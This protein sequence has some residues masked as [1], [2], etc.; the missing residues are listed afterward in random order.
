MSTRLLLVV[1]ALAAPRIARAEVPA[2]CG[3]NHGSY[4]DRQ[5]ALDPD[6]ERAVAGIIDGLC[7]KS[8]YGNDAPGEPELEQ[9]RRV[10]SQRL[11]MTDADWADAAVWEHHA[12]L[13]R[14][15]STKVL[16]KMTAVD[17]LTL[18]LDPFPPA[19]APYLADVLEGHL[20]EAG[21]LALLIAC[22]GEGAKPIT[23]GQAGA[24]A[25][26]RG[27]LD[28]FDFKKLSDQLH[29]DTTS[30]GA[31]RFWARLHGYEMAQRIALVR[32]ATQKLVA[33]DAEYQKV[34]DTASAARSEWAKTLGTNTELLELAL[35]IDSGVLMKSQRQLEGCEAKTDAALAA[36]VATI[37]ARAFVGMHDQRDEP[38][39][40]FVHAVGPLLA[41]TPAT[42]LAL[43]AYV[44]CQPKRDNVQGAGHYL[45]DVPGF[46]GPRGA[47][48]SALLETAFKFDDPR[49]SVGFRYGERP[50]LGM[51]D[52]TRSAGGVVKS[53]RKT[54]KG[55]VVALVKTQIVQD[56]C[57]ASHDTGRITGIRDG[58]VEYQRVCD[59]TASVTH[60]TTW[61]DFELDAR[62]ASVLKPGVMFSAAGTDVIAV[63]PSKTAKTPSWVLGG[64]V[65]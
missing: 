16:A 53:V 36:A 4:S 41:S 8:R 15:L 30:S 43:I 20:T 51:I 25:V 31:S 19:S 18:M 27:D 65:K 45:N 42:N 35:G 50:Y 60:D 52:R 38:E 39:R 5:A 13:G 46:R 61:D 40:G 48:A 1:A 24:L 58:K 26:C 59:K 14:A 33:D 55:I 56:E 21:R 12:D 44:E 6:A 10:W 49:T 23:A 2:W 32:A 9:A 63:W 62:Y 47:A 64:T 3:D 17:Q 11:L 57:V 54:D 37:P 22:V 28:Q 29:S 7:A 34:F